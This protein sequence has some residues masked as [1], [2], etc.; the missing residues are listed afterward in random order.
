VGE[1]TEL[2]VLLNR[3]IGQPVAHVQEITPTFRKALSRRWD[4]RAFRAFAK[5]L[6]RL[7]GKSWFDWDH[8]VPEQW[9]RLMIADRVLAYVALRFSLIIA[10]EDLA[11][12]LAALIERHGVECLYVLDF[13]EKSLSIDSSLL[14]AAFDFHNEHRSVVFDARLFSVS[15][16]WYET[17]AS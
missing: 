7:V 10:R 9:G 8:A 14:R 3:I 17:V 6:C 12:V 15:E 13:D 5:D 11:S 4:V 2:Q 1:F 16:L